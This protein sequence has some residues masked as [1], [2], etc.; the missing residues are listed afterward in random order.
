MSK[1]LSSKWAG[2]SVSHGTLRQQDLVEAFAKVLGEVN[3]PLADS[4]IEAFAIGDDDTQDYVLEQLFDSLDE[5]APEGTYF[6]AHP[7]DGSDFGFWS[8]SFLD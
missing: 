8:T 4:L 7:G 2:Q 1:Q 3:E 5:I 6:G